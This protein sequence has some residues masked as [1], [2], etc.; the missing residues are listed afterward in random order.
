M[1]LR[2]CDRC[3]R[4]TLMEKCRKCG[5]STVNPHPPK[6]SPVDPYG[7]YRRKLKLEY[8]TRAAGD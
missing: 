1:K 8:I 6:F 2:R 4:Y 3:G 7:K 5:S